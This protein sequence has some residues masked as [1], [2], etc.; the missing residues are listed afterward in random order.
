MAVTEKAAPIVKSFPLPGTTGIE[1]EISP[2]ATNVEYD[3]KMTKRLV[4][5]L[6]WHILPVLV[7]LYLLSFLDRT[8]I[9]NARL[10]NLEVDLGMKGLDYN[11]STV[12]SNV[13]PWNGVNHI[14][15]NPDRS[16]CSLPFLRRR[17][18]P[19]QY[20]DEANATVSLASLHNGRVGSS[21]YLDG[22]CDQLRRPFGCARRSRAC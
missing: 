5:K 16:G 8:N 21:L 1:V 18:N 20:Y 10:A 22:S 15:Y 19:L 9:G 6:D 17:R 11:V 3:E 7:I 4:R 2:T 12:R 13:P 14:F